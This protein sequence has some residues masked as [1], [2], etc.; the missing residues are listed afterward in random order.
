MAS[1]N[2]MKDARAT[3]DS[4]LST[5]KMASPIIIV[6]VVTVIYLLAH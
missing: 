4:F 5:I 2:D 3:Y 6:I 1:G